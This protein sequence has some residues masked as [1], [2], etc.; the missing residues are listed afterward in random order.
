MSVPVGTGVT[1]LVLAVPGAAI[2]VGVSGLR[3]AGSGVGSRPAGVQ[4]KAEFPNTEHTAS[5]R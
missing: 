3:S 1:G 4:A 2:N 5:A